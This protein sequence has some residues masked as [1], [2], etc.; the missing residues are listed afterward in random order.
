MAENISQRC[1]K[2]GEEVRRVL[3]K[4]I[5]TQGFYDPNLMDL[6]LTISE[7]RVSPDLKHAV[8]FVMPLGGLEN[9]Q[10]LLIAL[11]NESHRLRY[12]LGKKIR[13]KYTPQLRFQI[14]VSFD[15]YDSLSKALNQ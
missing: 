6:S 13:T 10:E 5:Q 12:E 11:Q 15:Q 8:V 3:S 2:V 4:I 1:L 9:N 14:D 7:V